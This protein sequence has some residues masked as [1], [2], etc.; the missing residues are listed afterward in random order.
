[1]ANYCEYNVIVKGRKNACYAFFGSMSCLD[2]KEIFDESGT[3]DDYTVK[4]NGNCKWSVDSYCTPWNG[5]FPVSL[6]EDADE[7]YEA[8]EELYWYNTVQERSKMFGVEVWCNSAD[9]E[10]YTVH[11]FELFEHYLCGDDMGSDY[12]G[13]NESGL[14]PDELRIYGIDED[15]GDSEGLCSC[16]RCS[17]LYS[18]DECFEMDEGVMICPVCYDKYYCFHRQVVE[19]AQDTAEETAE[20]IT[21]EVT[22]ESAEKIAEDIVPEA[23]EETAPEIP[24]IAPETASETT[25][26]TAPE[27][28]DES[29]DE[30]AAPEVEWEELII[31]GSL[32]GQKD[33]EE[34]STETADEAPAQDTVP[35]TEAG[36]GKRS[37]AWI[38][39]LIIAAVIIALAAVYVFCPPAADAVNDLIS[40]VIALF[41]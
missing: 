11:P 25:E 9:V 6:P 8:G 27:T 3:D 31:P 23:A 7:A 38:V 33:A 19:P 2:S 26:N 10:D 14:C 13:F 41:E 4:F 22:E 35:E 29:V 21:P 30:E 37:R 20:D 12:S 40:R 24:E 36:P 5:E 17:E 15:D 32:A 28:A 1:M 16:A 39:W 34:N 18:E